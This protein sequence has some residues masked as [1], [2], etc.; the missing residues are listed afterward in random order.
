KSRPFTFLDHALKCGDSLMGV[1]NLHQIQN[2]SI[3]VG[4]RQISFESARFFSYVDDA[5]AKRRALEA[6]PTDD[7]EQLK[8][9]SGLYA[10]AESATEKLRAVADF[11]IVLEMQG[12][13][14][15][16]YEDAR[17]CEAGR[18]QTLLNR[19]A[20]STSEVGSQASELVNAA[21][22]ARRN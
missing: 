5:R 2:F 15:H 3:R 14:G 1:G 19:Y 21:R 16:D 18:I 20:N 12:L 17:Q 22:E 11:L 8:V 10:E 13:N 9:K 7:L 6:L 4:P